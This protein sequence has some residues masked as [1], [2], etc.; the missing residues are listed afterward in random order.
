[1]SE[2]EKSRETHDKRREGEHGKRDEAN[3][4]RKH[5]GEFSRAHNDPKDTVDAAV[6]DLE[7]Q[8]GRDMDPGLKDATH[9][10]AIRH[11]TE[12]QRRGNEERDRGEFK[13]EGDRRKKRDGESDEERRIRLEDDE[14]RRRDDAGLTRETDQE[15]QNRELQEASQQDQEGCI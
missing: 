4:P 14:R 10:G 15:R 7:R 3:D 9:D 11:T 1:M 6:K 5:S 2:H 12:D 13:V 8:A